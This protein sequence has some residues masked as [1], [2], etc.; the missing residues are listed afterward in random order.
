MFV[1]RYYPS[2]S[3]LRQTV[4]LSDPFHAIITERVSPSVILLYSNRISHG[5]DYRNKLLFL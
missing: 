2:S 4:Q 1:T 3:L 5:Q